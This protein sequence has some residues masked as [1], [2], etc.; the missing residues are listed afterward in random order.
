M[1]TDLFQSKLFIS[2]HAPGGVRLWLGPS[3]SFDP[4]GAECLHWDAW[5]ENME[6]YRP[7]GT[8]WFR[9][10]QVETEYLFSH[11]GLPA[12]LC[13]KPRIRHRPDPCDATEEIPTHYRV[14]LPGVWSRWK[15]WL[16]HTVSNREDI[17]PGTLEQFDAMLLSWEAGVTFRLWQSSDDG[18]GDCPDFYTFFGAPGTPPDAWLVPDVDEVCSGNVGSGGYRAPSP[19]D[20]PMPDF[21]CSPGTTGI[22]QS[23][24]WFHRG[25]LWLACA[26]DGLITPRYIFPLTGSPFGFLEARYWRDMS[27]VGEVYYQQERLEMLALMQTEFQFNGET[28]TTLPVS[29]FAEGFEI[30]ISIRFELNL[31]GGFSPP[32]PPYATSY[33]Y[34]GVLRV[35]P[36]A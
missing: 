20:F 26:G 24:A 2:S 8:N 17:C 25:A 10:Q 32:G 11:P 30:S 5:Y 23:I 12:C 29:A 21:A 13:V 22:S 28:R 33:R 15:A 3:D 35:E 1:P 16:F 31:G 36:A 7:G 6:W 9:R 4:S 14:S 18:F 34:T 27:Y 19:D